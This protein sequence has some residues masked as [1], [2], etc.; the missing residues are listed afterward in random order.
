MAAS[1]EQEQQQRHIVLRRP[2]LTLCR[3][4]HE[5]SNSQLHCV[6]DSSG[7]CSMIPDPSVLG[8]ATNNT[9]TRCQGAAYVYTSLGEP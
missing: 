1:L 6:E 2:Q 5:A 9:I 7:F 3:I 4:Y 8:L